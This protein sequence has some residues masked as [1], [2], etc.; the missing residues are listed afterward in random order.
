MRNNKSLFVV[1]AILAAAGLA[2]A[3]PA[4]KV[5]VLSY[6]IDA[7][8]EADRIVST[9]VLTIHSKSSV[10]KLELE[11]AG[12][13]KIESCRL[14]EID[15]P[16]ERAGW[17]LELDF[18]GVGAPKGEFSVVFDL[19]GKPYVKFSKKRG[20]FVRTNVCAE[21]AYI[22]S[23]YAWYPRREHD[24]ARYD[25]SLEVRK[26]WMVRTAGNLEEKRDKNGRMLWRYVLDEPDRGI[27]LAAGDYVEVEHETKGGMTLDAM[28]FPGHEGGGRALL[29]VADRA[30]DFYSS[31]YGP[32]AKG[33][34]TLVEVPAPFG[35]G[36]GYGEIGYA[37]VGAGAF[38]EEGSASFAESLVAHEVCHTWW[39]HEVRF[40]HFAS[41]SFATYATNRYME[42]AKGKEIARE[43]RWKFVN[44]IVST[45]PVGEIPLDEIR[46]WGGKLNPS[47]YRSHAYEKGAMLLHIL[48]SEMTRKAFDASVRKFFEKH[49]GSLIDFN[50]VRKDLV[51]S[52]WKWI[53]NQ[54]AEPGIPQIR[55]EHETK[56]SGSSYAVKGTL[57]QE[58][59]EKPFKMTVCLR[60]VKG[61]RTFDHKV[62]LKKG[63]ASFRF[64]CPFEPEEI[65]IDPGCDIICRA[66]GLEDTETLKKN[67]W[68]V[69]SNPGMGDKNALKR[70]INNI[71]KLI[72]AGI[73]HESSYHT[74]MGRC[75][76]RMNDFDEAKK[77]FEIAL[78]GG[79]GGP[80]H[81]TWIYLRLGCIADVEKKRSDAETYYNKVLAFPDKP[82][83]EFQKELA[84]RF[85]EKPYKGYEKDG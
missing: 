2:A 82:N 65:V 39:G 9:V 18:S 68:D 71:R 81:R 20:G 80:F 50:V 26:D 41:E 22:R 54:W 74:A 55:E 48:E 28:V 25:T 21:H 66:A 14:N 51:P 34:Y 23:Q 52:K 70:T 83:H 59:T 60:A 64:T 31:L 78:K 75:F 8:I 61:E 27:G 79:G 63:K 45:I 3:A 58:G 5:D 57:F 37:L 42:M 49:R 67:I 24:S 36:S 62:V 47:V 44:K 12:A 4:D 15:V 84:N 30:I 32:I 46:D 11:L 1:F 38:E 29:A 72:S 7:S 56:K 73:E 35:R 43:E 10:R 33:R 16:F 76:F 13:M 53:I 6:K 85:L 19:E 17:D 77:E 40:R 69:V